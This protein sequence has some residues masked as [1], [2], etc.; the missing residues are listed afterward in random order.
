MS[1]FVS[2]LIP[3]YNAGKF[4]TKCLESI[5]SQGFNDYEIIVSD[6]GSTDD[7]LDKV[8]VF[9]KMH[10]ELDITITSNPNGGVSLARKRAL[11]CATGKWV[12]FVDSDD[13]L[14]CNALKSLCCQ[15]GDDTDL[16][17]GFVASPSNKHSYNSLDKPLQ[18]QYAIIQ[19]L[20]SFSVWGKLYRRS[21]LTPSMLDVPRKI[22]NGE[23][24]L[25]NIA[26]AFAMKRPPKFTFDNIYNYTRN[27]ISLSHTTKR[28]LDYEYLYDSLRT[29]IIPSSIIN[30]FMVPITKDRINGVLGCC[31]SDADAISKKTHPFFEEIKNGISQ[32]G[33]KLSMFEWIVLNI[34]SPSIIKCT[35]LFR[36]ILNSLKYRT[37]LLFRTH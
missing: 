20:I 13:S 18:W 7:T 24:A 37:S 35:G 29:K 17:V 23:D 3:A 30:E 15:A 2:V 5:R 28:S 9:K 14:P 26:Y 8:S 10:P 19:G 32:T 21:L 27:P 4:I 36:S 12:T 11:E 34:E 33:Y 22:T 1:K 25:M 31:R 16:V 6:D